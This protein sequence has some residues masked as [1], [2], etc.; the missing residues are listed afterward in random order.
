MP[1]AS[2]GTAAKQSGVGIETIRYY[3]R[4][5]IIP[6]ARRAANGRRVYDENDIA[7][8]KFVRRG[9]DLGFSIADI[10]S[11]LNL[12]SDHGST[13]DEVKA[14]G[15]AHLRRVRTKVAELRRIEQALAELVHLCNEGRTAC[16]MLQALSSK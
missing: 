10:K 15:E 9:R 7:R 3:E 16:P 11:F 4:E 8:L 14:I 6:A 2:I 5:G 12:A 1:M 13:C